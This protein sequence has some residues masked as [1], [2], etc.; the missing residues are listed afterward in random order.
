MICS[1]IVSCICHD[2]KHPGLNNNF[3]IETNDNIALT[4]NDI[5]VLENMHVSEAFKLMHSDNNCNIFEGIDKDKYKIMRKQIINC[6]L[7]TDMAR[8]SISVEFLK[9]C[10][11]EDNK[12]EENDKQDYM[13]VIIHTSDISNPTKIFDIYLNWAKLV[14]EEF[15]DQGDKEKNLGLKCFCD[16]NKVTIYQNQLGFIDY[17]EMPFF[18][19]VAKAFPKLDFLFENLNNNKQTILKMQ[20]ENNKKK[21]EIEV[22]VK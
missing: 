4:Y 13:N 2:F 15:Y 6:V 21:E 11:K 9:K 10:L 22:K 20:E 18:S 8:H 14:V 3:L 17:I 16:R 12:P 7:S 19:L 1:V 5:S